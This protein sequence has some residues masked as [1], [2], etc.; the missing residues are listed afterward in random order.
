MEENK[1]KELSYE[2]LKEVAVQLQK[3]CAF[4][5]Q[6]LRSFD[7]VSLRLNYLFKVLEV[8]EA[9]NYDFIEKCAKE[10]EELL[11]VE[12]AEDLPTGESE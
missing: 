10:V 7:M 8:K 12:E 9:F 6:K 4:A 2:E 11:T 1:K 5:E 3:R